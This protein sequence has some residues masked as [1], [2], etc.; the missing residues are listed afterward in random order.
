VVDKLSEILEGYVDKI[1][2]RNAENGYTVL[3]LVNDEVEMTCVGTFTFIGEGEFIKAT[4]SYTAH[5]LY[6][7]NFRSRVMNSWNRK[8]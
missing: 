3:T 7:N 8:I 2:F 1:V 4:G 5:Q 6:E